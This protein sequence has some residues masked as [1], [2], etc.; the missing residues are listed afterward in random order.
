MQNSCALSVLLLLL[1]LSS[2]CSGV[3][4]TQIIASPTAT[5]TP[6]RLGPTSTPP[7][8]EPPSTQPGAPTSAPLS[9]ITDADR[10]RGPQDAPVTLVV[11]CDYQ[12]PGCVQLAPILDI[13]REWHPDD[14]RVVHRLFPLIGIQDK[15]SLAAQAVL[16]AEKQGAFWEMH[17]ALYR[18]FEAWLSLEPSAFENWLFDLASEIGLDQD[19][20]QTALKEGEYAEAVQTMY[21]ESAAAGISVSPFVFLN[22]EWFRTPLN[23][24]NLEM[25]VRL[26]ALT[27]RQYQTYPPFTID[28]QRE[29]YARVSL[30]VGEVLIQ[31][32]PLSAP[33][34]VNNFIF[35]AQD[36]WYDG[37]AFYKVVPERYVETGDPSD[38]GLGDPGYHFADEIDPARRFDQPGVLAM[39][40]GGPDTNGS[41]FLI[42]LSSV[43]E[44][45]DNYT[46]FGKVV[47]GLELLTQLE[48]RDPFEDFLAPAP[49]IIQSI[50]I[51]VR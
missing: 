27:N 34:A 17:D 29:Y 6:P 39:V 47:Q 37:V 45:N 8:F 16:A 41:R 43:P 4:S 30:D 3:S 42:T 2:T 26:S 1:T 40:S 22:G 50:E 51:D 5:R 21:E 11:Y 48:T 35:L 31:L 46:I 44:W 23:L 12:T 15:S 25:A 32:Y 7:R 10:V 13:L 24:V 20:F 14:L 36:G 9:P 38:T 19:S 18:E 33:M 49:A 28:L